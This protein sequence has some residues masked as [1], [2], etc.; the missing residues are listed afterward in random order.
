[1]LNAA[2]LQTKLVGLMRQYSGA[3]ETPPATVYSG[4]CHEQL[5]RQNIIDGVCLMS[6]FLGMAGSA[7]DVDLYRLNLAYLIDLELRDRINELLES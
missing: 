7:G 3:V 2:Q 4:D 5:T 1:M 6:R